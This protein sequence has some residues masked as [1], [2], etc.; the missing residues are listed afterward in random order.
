MANIFYHPHQALLDQYKSGVFA[1]KG[2]SS[3]SCSSGDDN[4]FRKSDN[5]I[6]NKNQFYNYD[7][8]SSASFLTGNLNDSLRK[9]NNGIFMAKNIKDQFN[10]KRRLGK[11][12]DRNNN[13]YLKQQQ[14]QAHSKFNSPYLNQYFEPS[15]QQSNILNNSANSSK[16][17][18]SNNSSKESNK[19]NVSK[20]QTIIKSSNKAVVSNCDCY[21]FNS[22]FNNEGI[23]VKTS[24]ISPL[25]SKYNLEDRYDIHQ[26]IGNG[27]FSDVYLLTLKDVNKREYEASKSFALKEINKSKMEGKN[28]FVENEVYLLKT[29]KH[30]NI[31]NLVEAYSTKTT[32]LLIF[33]LASKGDLFEAV[34]KLGHL[35]ETTASSITFQIASALAYLH[36]NNIVHRDIKPENILLDSDLTVKLS[37]F[38]LACYVPK[39]TFLSRI[40]GTMSYVSPEVIIGKYG[41]ECD[42]WSLG[43][44]FHIMLVGHAP[45]RSQNR[46]KLFKLISRAQFS[47]DHESWIPIS[48]EAR[49]LVLRLLTLDVNRRIKAEEVLHHPFLKNVLN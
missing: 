22:T 26:K 28:F 8:R 39:N 23:V 20:I 41:I 5:K 21:T 19:T 49:N 12:L 33:E 37:D 7:R 38:G 44:V 9:C 43:V 13:V 46:Q 40:C 14:Q 25:K 3:T 42:M 35:S 6:R 48:R 10:V 1:K 32:Y 30:Q 36:S 29:Y 15:I 45:F 16:E 31:C 4:D 18:I 2:T 47:M 17:D 27:N 34:K 24:F 11:S